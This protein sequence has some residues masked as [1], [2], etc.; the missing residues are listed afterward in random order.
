[1]V[2]SEV[3]CADVVGS[4]SNERFLVSLV[5]RSRVLKLVQLRGP[6]QNVRPAV[7]YSPPSHDR[8]DSN[9]EDTK[10]SRF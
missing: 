9:V 10:T 6:L 1:M 8:T 3:V 7:L 2:V 4:T 5:V